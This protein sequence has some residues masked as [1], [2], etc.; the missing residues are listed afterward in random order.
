MVVIWDRE[1]QLSGL[2]NVLQ[3]GRKNINGGD[4]DIE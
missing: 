1:V 3:Q 4:G 2:K